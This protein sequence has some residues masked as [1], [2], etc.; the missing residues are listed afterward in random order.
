MHDALPPPSPSVNAARPGGD[1]FA[2]VDDESIARLVD[3]FYS[4][5]RLDPDLGPVFENAIASDAWEPHLATMRNFWSSVM[6]TTG[7]YKGNPLAVHGRVEGIRPELFERWLELFGQTADELFEAG[8]A[9]VFKLKAERI[10]QSL[11][12]GLFYRPELDRPRAAS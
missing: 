4:K 7:R 1:R 11:L 12:V 6:L 9:G 8:V 5:V 3:G 2:T 10:A